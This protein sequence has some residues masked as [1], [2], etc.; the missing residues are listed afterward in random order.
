[1]RLNSHHREWGGRSRIGRLL[2]RRCDTFSVR[3][4]WGRGKTLEIAEKEFDAGSGVCVA[5]HLG[6]THRD[7]IATLRQWGDFL[8]MRGKTRGAGRDDE[9]RLCAFSAK[10][11]R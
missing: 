5:R 9:T 1:M 4:R 8:G 2:K 6:E 3:Q 7:T 11:E 10:K